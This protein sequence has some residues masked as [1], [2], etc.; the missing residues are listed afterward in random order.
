MKLYTFPPA[1]NPRRLAIFLAEKGIALDTQLV[2]LRGGEQFLQQY[3]A[4]NPRETVPAL[5]LDDGTLLTEVVGMYIYLESLYPD[6]PLLGS[7]PLSRA[8]IISWDHRCFVDGFQAV[9]ETLRNS[10]KA[11]AGHALPGPVGYEQIPELAARGRQR[12]QAFY[13]VLDAHLQGREYIVGK[14]FSVADIAAW[15][16]VEFSGWV[17]EQVPEACTAL[18]EWCEKTRIRPSIQQRD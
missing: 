11:F 12:I 16:F 3:Q 4:V 18:A 17:K 8:E 15:V 2:D 1:P 10:N 5:V 13:R 7:D 9:A 6:Q 14:N